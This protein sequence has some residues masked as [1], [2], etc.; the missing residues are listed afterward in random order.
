M[1]SDT[2]GLDE[3]KIRKFMEDIKIRDPELIDEYSFSSYI[4]N[5]FPDV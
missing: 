5:K 2:F 4:M 3:Y 1:D